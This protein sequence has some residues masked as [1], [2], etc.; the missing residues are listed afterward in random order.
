MAKTKRQKT[1]ENIRESLIMQLHGMGANVAHFEN[2][3][4]DYLS[5]W[6]TKAKLNEDIKTRGIVYEDF[7]AS[8]VSMKKNNPSVKDVVTVSRQMLMILD[9]L[10]IDTKNVP[11]GGEDDL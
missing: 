1:R 5:F 6:D 9:K 8:G 2:L 7:S 3:I 4:E 11:D 10:G